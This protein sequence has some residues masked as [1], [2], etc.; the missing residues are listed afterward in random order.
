MTGAGRGSCTD[1]SALCCTDTSCSTSRGATAAAVHSCDCVTPTS[2][3]SQ[4]VPEAAQLPASLGTIDADTVSTVF[5][6]FYSSP[7]KGSKA[8][9]PAS[10]SPFPVVCTWKSL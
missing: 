5:W 10:S 8:E 9:A 1:D 6:C 4:C 2:A 3:I 7:C